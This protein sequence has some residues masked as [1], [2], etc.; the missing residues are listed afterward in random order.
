MNQR[1]P[2][3]RPVAVPPARYRPTGNIARDLLEF[4]AGYP[5]VLVG[6]VM[7]LF[8]LEQSTAA[9]R[10]DE[11]AS[12]GLVRS[13]SRL[14]HQRGCYQMTAAGLAEIDSD[15]PVP[16]VDLRRYWRDV[17][18]AS[19]GVAVRKGAFG[20][21]VERFFTERE[22]RGV[23][24]KATLASAT[25]GDW[26]PAARA[27]AADASFGLTVGGDASTSAGSLHY[28]DIVVV[29]GPVGRVAIE[30]CLEPPNSSRLGGVLS[31]YAQ[32]S[33]VA[34][35][36]FYFQDR[37]SRELTR[38]A[39]EKH[40]LGDRMRFELTRLDVLSPSEGFGLTAPYADPSVSASW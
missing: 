28:P 37:S 3:P 29:F 40:G 1:R 11:L 16:R 19:L 20:D 12:R 18:V 31:A 36:V 22:M 23:D 25:D 33:T 8:E 17:G 32:K 6:Q 38:T 30:L 2:D 7:T 9:S 27:K 5:I 10:L 13:C 34:A 14:R 24:R 35:A 4:M 39:A 26:A 15:L 21:D